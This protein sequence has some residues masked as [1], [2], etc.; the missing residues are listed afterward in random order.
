MTTAA[1]EI[2]TAS[3]SAAAVARTRSNLTAR[4][5]SLELKRSILARNAAFCDLR[6]LLR[7]AAL[8]FAWFIYSARRCSRSLRPLDVRGVHIICSRAEF[9][10]ST[11]VFAARTTRLFYSNV[12]DFGPFGGLPPSHGFT[13]AQFVFARLERSFYRSEPR[14][15]SLTNATNAPTTQMSA[16]NDASQS[17]DSANSLIDRSSAA[18]S[19]KKRDA[20]SATSEDDAAPAS[21]AASDAPTASRDAKRRRVEDPDESTTES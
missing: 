10:F 2:A 4:P 19:T 17:E 15:E 3:S 21:D 16:T 11:R 9:F 8:R 7:A 14:Q 18:A 20:P 5:R 12:I 13:P 6:G 1:V